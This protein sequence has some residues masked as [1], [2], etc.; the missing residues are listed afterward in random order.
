MNASIKRAPRAVAKKTT[1]TAER[2]AYLATL[3]PKIRKLNEKLIPL[4]GKL[5]AALSLKKW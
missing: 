1:L 2:K 3:T 5:T 4:E